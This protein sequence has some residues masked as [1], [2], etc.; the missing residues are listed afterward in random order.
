[1]R[2]IIRLQPRVPV[3]WRNHDDLQIGVDPAYAIL[4]SP[5]PDMVRAVA[6]MIRGTTR[7]QLVDIV[8]D[9]AAT[10]LLTQ[11]GSACTPAPIPPAL[12][13]VIEGGLACAPSVATILRHAGHHVSVL[14]TADDDFIGRPDV[15]LIGSTYTVSPL[16]YQRWLANDVPHIPVVIGDH[17]I[18]VGPRVVPGL[19]ACVAC[20]ERHRTD[21]DESWPAIAMQLWGRASRLDSP[22]SSPHIAGAV[23]HLLADALGTALRIDTATQH[24]TF[25]RWEHHPL[26]EC[27]ALAVTANRK[28][29]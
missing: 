4:R 1:M 9:A 17:I 26:C 21:A 10:V 24:R 7:D 2:V 23:L 22:R 14:D 28:I 29:D 15:A 5:T 11:I 27:A 6:A 12:R 16:S 25:T 19:T 8:G 3:V 18:T 13:I 20:I